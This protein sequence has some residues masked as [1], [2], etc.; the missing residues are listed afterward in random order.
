MIAERKGFQKVYDL[1]EHVLPSG[2]DTK[3]PTTDEYATYLIKNTLQ[4]HGFASAKEMAYLRKGMS[5][6]VQRMLNEMLK[7]NEII[8]ILIEGV[9]EKQYT[10][11]E[12]LNFKQENNQTTVSLLS[13]FD[14]AVI[15]LNRLKNIFDFNYGV[16]CY[17]PEH[18]RKF[19]YFC[20]PILYGNN[21]VGRLDPKADRH[22]KEF[23]IKSL[24]IEH[25]PADMDKFLSSLA[26]SIKEF[27][28]F[29]ECEKITIKKTFPSKIKAGLKSF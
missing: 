5:T 10:F 3:T 29:N 9:K 23:I 24:H 18:K 1:A 26:I 11:P 21:F 20:L 19:G 6:H 8:E 4:A 14:N 2:I 22:K 27:A 25:P 15:M 17:L 13:P 28:S 12:T 16:E 7:E